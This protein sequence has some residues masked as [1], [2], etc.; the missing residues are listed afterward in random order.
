MDVLLEEYESEGT[1]VVAFA[2]DLLVMVEGNNRRELEHRGSTA[3][4]V[5]V[6]WGETVGV[7]VSTQKTCCMLLKGRLADTRPPVVRSGNFTVE[8]EVG[9]SATPRG[10][11]GQDSDSSW[12]PAESPAHGV[13]A[14][15]RAV[16]CLFKGLLTECALYGSSIW[17]RTLRTVLLM[18]EIPWVLEAERR[19]LTFK[20]KREIPVEPGD[21]VSNDEIADIRTVRSSGWIDPCMAAAAGYLITRHGSMNGFLYQRGLAE[22]DDAFM[23]TD[24]GNEGDR[25]K[26]TEDN[27][28]TSETACNDWDP[29]DDLPL[30]VYVHSTRQ[31]TS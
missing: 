10:I 2:D 26:A 7:S 30:A 11:K 23:K 17:Y 5:A 8:R 12:A 9:F 15:K 25:T 24:E 29:E 27:S 28:K 4:S 21:I 13:G 18:G 31:S 20:A 16:R 3:L 6:R 19:A 22:N 14:E 1:S